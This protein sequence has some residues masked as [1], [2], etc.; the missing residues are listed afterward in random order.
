MWPLWACG[1]F[2]SD[3]SQCRLSELSITCILL[4]FSHIGM[5]YKLNR[6][7]TELQGVARATS[8]T[9]YRPAFPRLAPCD[10]RLAQPVG[11]NPTRRAKG[12]CSYLGPRC[13]RACG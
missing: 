1:V 6:F 3:F 10:S 13:C 11:I 5:S 12:G 9:T 2:A 4:V 8:T 7:Q